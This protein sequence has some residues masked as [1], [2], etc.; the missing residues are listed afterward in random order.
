MPVLTAD[1]VDKV[2]RKGG[3]ARLPDPLPARFRP[4][5]KV[6]ARNI[7]P[8]GHTRIP[9]YLRGCVGV[10]HRDQGVFI[11]PD[12]HAAGEKVPQRL[13]SVRFTG[14]ALWGPQGTAGAAVYVDLFESYLVP[15]P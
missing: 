12:A 6:R 4:G 9:R 13:Y 5:D 11:F 10:V 2:L 15:A 3:S 7:N 8:P 14:A 1:N